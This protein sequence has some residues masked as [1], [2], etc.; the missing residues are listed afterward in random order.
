M[1]A[2]CLIV[3]P[4][5]PSSRTTKVLTFY[6]AEFM[7]PSE[8]GYI[9]HREKKNRKLCQIEEVRYPWTNAFLKISCFQKQNI[10]KNTLSGNI[11]HAVFYFIK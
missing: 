1:W 2:I 4:Q 5:I 6:M 3:K 10:C 7:L 8:P 9:R 11:S